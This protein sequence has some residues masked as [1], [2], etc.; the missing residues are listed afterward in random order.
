MDSTWVT[1]NTWATLGCHHNVT[2]VLKDK[3]NLVSEKEENH[4]FV[5][6]CICD[7]V[8]DQSHMILIP[9]CHSSATP[10]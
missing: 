1:E 9:Q 2:R 3:K 8:V 4:N 7:I 6:L 10:W 5:F